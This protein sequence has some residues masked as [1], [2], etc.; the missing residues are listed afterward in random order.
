METD[1]DLDKI[2]RQEYVPNEVIGQKHSKKPKQ[3]RKK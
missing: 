2:R 1:R 3:N